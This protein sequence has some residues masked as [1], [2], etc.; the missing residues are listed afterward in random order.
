[1]IE[2]P[3]NAKDDEWVVTVGRYILNMGA[4]ERD[5]AN[6]AAPVMPS[7]KPHM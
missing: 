7:V 5:A 4:L 3:F 6:S 2:P 1:M